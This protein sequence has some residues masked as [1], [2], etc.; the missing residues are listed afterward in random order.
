MIMFGGILTI[1]NE[2][3][4]EKIFISKQKE[5]SEN[6]QKF[7]NI[8]KEKDIKVNIVKAGDRIVFEKNLYM[9]ILW[10]TEQQIT[11]NPLNNNSIVAKLV[12]KSF[13]MLFTGDIE[14]IAEEAILKRYKKKLNILK[15]NILKVAH[16]GSKTSSTKDFLKAVSPKIVLIGVGENNTFGHPSELILKRI[17]SIKSTIYRTDKCGEITIESNGADMKI[18][19]QII[20]K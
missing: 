18:K 19:H 5:N 16:H 3:K 10:P 6:Y 2:I 7:L 8:V 17:K 9:T 12:Y 14:E 15:S 11:E 20:K 1:I 4:V 13:S